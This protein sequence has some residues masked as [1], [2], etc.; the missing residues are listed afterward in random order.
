MLKHADLTEI[1]SFMQTQIQFAQHI[2]DPQQQPKPVDVDDRR[3]AIYRDLLYNNI[4][5]FLSSG[6]PVI[7]TIYSEEH[8]HKLVRDFFI[9]HRCETPYFLEISQ[10]FI[11]YLQ[12]DREPQDED[13]AGLIE[14]A[15][16]EWVE[17]ALS[18]S[19]QEVRLGQINPNGDLLKSHP[20]VSPLAW[21]LVYQFPVHMMSRDFLP[22]LAPEQLT[23]LVIYRDRLD[24]IHFMEINAVTAHLLIQ[25]NENS[26][27]SGYEILEDIANQLNAA[28]PKAVIR[29]GLTSMLELQA[30]GI[31]LGTKKSEV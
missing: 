26:T 16:Y 3:M 15:H 9:K 29:A 31:I 7:R 10:E 5:N 6:F 21:T 20:V 19:D 13:P 11:N 30:K 22:N 2:R 8:W 18:T 17:L 27:T 1:P 14:L 24:E 25:L 23:Y 12:N 28:N 4:E